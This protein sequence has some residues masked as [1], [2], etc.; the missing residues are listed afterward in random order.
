MVRGDEGE[1]QGVGYAE[2]GNAVMY[3]DVW[4]VEQ[5]RAAIESGHRLYTLSPSGCYAKV[6]RT[7]LGIRAIPDHDGGDMIDELPVCG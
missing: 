3:D 1:L 6:E 2:N 7:E 4:T 5:A